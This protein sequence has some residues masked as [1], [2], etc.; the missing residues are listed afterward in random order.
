MFREV[1]DSKW[2]ADHIARHGVTLNEVREAILQRPYWQVE[3]KGDTV[4]IYGR[5]H[6]GRY[7]FVVAADDDGDA[8]IV[9]ARDMTPSERKTF[10]RKA[11]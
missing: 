10:Q 6:A 4:L 1:K 11:R 5:I 7:L 9:T 3:G 8:F 2:S